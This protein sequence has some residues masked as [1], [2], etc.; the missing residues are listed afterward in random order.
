MRRTN[1]IRK[2]C[3]RLAV[4]MLIVESSR[5]KNRTAEAH[6]QTRSFTRSM[7]SRRTL[8]CWFR[9]STDV[10]A[11][12]MTIPSKYS[13]TEIRTKIDANIPNAS[14]MYVCR[15]ED[16]LWRYLWESQCDYQARG[17]KRLARYVASPGTCSIPSSCIL[18]EPR[19][20]RGAPSRFPRTSRL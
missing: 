5:T 1:S 9:A 7:T 13:Y 2:A 18:P 20:S 3:R 6:N 16:V 10:K 12:S 8:V 11:M 4:A 17:P 14:C 19:I 15:H